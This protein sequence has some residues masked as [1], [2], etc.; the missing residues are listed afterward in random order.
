LGYLGVKKQ[1][2]DV[3]SREDDESKTFAPPFFALYND[4]REITYPGSSSNTRLRSIHEVKLVNSYI[5]AAKTFGEDY[6]KVLEY[7]QQMSVSNYY[8]ETNELNSFEMGLPISYNGGFSPVSP[9]DA[10]YGNRN[11]Y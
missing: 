4:K 2:T 1:D 5:Q 8:E 6:N 7:I 10:F 11:P 9:Y 3:Q